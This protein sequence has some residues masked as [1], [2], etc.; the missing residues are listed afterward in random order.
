[1]AGGIQGEHVVNTRKQD[2]QAML[3]RA[4]RAALLTLV[5]AI[6]KVYPRGLGVP[7]PIRPAD[8]DDR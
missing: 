7:D 1:M 3:W 4:V 2:T 5:A 6:D 8:E